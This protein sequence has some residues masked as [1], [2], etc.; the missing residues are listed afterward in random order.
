MSDAPEHDDPL[1]DNTDGKPSDK[2]EYE[3]ADSDMTTGRDGVDNFVSLGSGSLRI[4][5]AEVGQKVLSLLGYILVIRS[6][7]V[8]NFGELTLALILFQIST[9][10][11]QLGL[12]SGVQHFIPKAD[13]DG[14]KRWIVSVV[15]KITSGLAVFLGVAIWVLAEPLLGVVFGQASITR[16]LQILALTL[17]FSVLYTISV[18]LVQSFEDS[19]PHVYIRKLL[20]PVLRVALIALA[21]I[22]GADLV[23]IAMAYSGTYILSSL[24]TLAYLYRVV[25]RLPPTT[26]DEYQVTEI[27]QFSLPLLGTGITMNLVRKID[28]VILGIFATTTGVALFQSVYTLS[29]NYLFFY[30]SM[31]FLFTP[32]FSRL[33]DEDNSALDQFYK[34]VT[35]WALYPSIG[36]I[37]FVFMFAEPLLG[38]L[39]KPEYVG[40]ATELRLLGVASV[41]TAFIG[42]AE[43]A[44][45]GLGNSRIRFI[46]SVFMLSTNTVLDLLLV[47]E[48]GV[49][50]A[51]AGSVVAATLTQ[52]IYAVKLYRMTG[53]HTLK[54]ETV[55]PVL[56]TASY[57]IVSWI[58]GVSEAAIVTR[59]GN[60]CA[61]VFLF[62]VVA[63]LS[64]GIERR[65]I[66]DARRILTRSI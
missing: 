7:S 17:P 52:V 65:D 41:V 66:N 24:L 61:F 39:F 55:I 59:V 64:G 44:V 32:M 4:L 54:Q 38:T 6:L 26:R 13:D 37:M 1:G 33:V 34:R 29:L 48:F 57:A 10:A 16:P 18:K 11:A 40:A 14:T 15:L 45:V 31:A 50:G 42:F 19:T 47:P 12:G 63:W 43:N 53:I 23:G 28:I 20:Y 58:I 36:V 60:Y 30:A 49:I 2:D 22:L 21:V 56:F 8:S 5:G 35:R 51:I 25:S 27:V 62:V 3:A 9:T 46:A